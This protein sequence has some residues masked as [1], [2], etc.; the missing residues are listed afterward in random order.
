LLVA[1]SS[2]EGLL[3]E[4]RTAAQPLAAR[5]GLHAPF[6]TSRQATFRH[7]AAARTIQPGTR[8]AI[9]RFG[10][11]SSTAISIA[12]KVARAGFRAAPNA[13][14]MRCAAQPKEAFN[15]RGAGA[16]AR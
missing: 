4:R 5:T 7:G 16:E 8:A 12:S 15:D 1:A 11:P 10:L 6:A 2:G 14:S 9:C 3:T 13:R